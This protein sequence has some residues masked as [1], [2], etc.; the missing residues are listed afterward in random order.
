M[1]LLNYTSFYFFVVLFMI[2]IVWAGSFYFIMLDEIYDSMD[3]GLENQKLL[4]L[5]KIE[6]DST[7]LQKKAFDEGN[8]LVRKIPSS[9]ANLQTDVY[10]DTLMYMQ[11]EADFEPVR[12]LLTAFEHKGTYYHMKVITSMVEEDD[13]IED[14]F[15]SLIFLFLGLTLSML[16]LNNVV[17]KKIWQ[18]FYGLLDK[19]QKFRLDEP[20]SFAPTGSKIEEFQ[21]LDSSVR[22]LLTSNIKT[23]NDQKQFI[24]NASHE[25]QTPLAICLN[26]LELLAE[27]PQPE[28]QLRLI[29]GVISSIERLIRL[30]K[31]L[32]LLSRISNQQFSGEEMVDFNELVVQVVEDFSD[33]STFKKITTS[34]DIRGDCHHKMHPD[35]AQILIVNLLKNAMVH[36]F[37]LGFVHIIVEDHSISFENSGKEVPLDVVRI[38]E[39]FY[40]NEAKENSTGLGLAIVKA[41]ADLYQLGLKY[42]YEKKHVFCLSFKN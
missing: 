29:G 32:L 6:E 34:V 28:E 14:L 19:L 4:V 38:F 5:Q 24:E 42:R 9:Q 23:F 36:N 18:P 2:L 33:Q 30:N 11:N 12:M 13:L 1:R 22:K 17:L 31:S 37:P 3:D 25:L 39:R 21:L 35:L 8:Y 27:F 7:L 26:K 15:F 40:K 16:V 20:M 10:A 41:I